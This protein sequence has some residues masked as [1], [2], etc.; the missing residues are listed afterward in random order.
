MPPEQHPLTTL[1]NRPV[2]DHVLFVFEVCVGAP[3]REE[4]L[5]RGLM[6]AWCIGR[7]RARE[8]NTDLAPRTRPST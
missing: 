8:A 7:I 2:L 5:I 1:A 3:L 6:L 4:I